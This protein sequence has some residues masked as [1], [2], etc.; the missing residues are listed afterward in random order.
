MSGWE[1]QSR[2]NYVIPEEDVEE[3]HIDASNETS[4]NVISE[5]YEVESPGQ[6]EIEE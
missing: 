2:T 1:D 5:D 4:N 3:S 6:S